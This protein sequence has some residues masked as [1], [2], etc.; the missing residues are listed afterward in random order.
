MEW[1][2]PQVCGNLKII[3]FNRKKNE[4]VNFLSIARRS[5][6]YMKSTYKKIW[7]FLLLFMSII[8]SILF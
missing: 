3:P 4:Y 5:Y 6:I 7:L 8:K 1:I 2:L